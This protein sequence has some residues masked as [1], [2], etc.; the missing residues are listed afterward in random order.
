MTVRQPHY[1]KEE[2]ARLGDEIYESHVRSQVEDGNYGMTDPQ[3]I[4]N[5]W[6]R[7]LTKQDVLNIPQIRLC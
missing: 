2:F 7:I 5:F 1:P 6:W 4:W 3:G